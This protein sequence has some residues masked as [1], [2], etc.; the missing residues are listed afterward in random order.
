MKKLSW[1]VILVSSLAMAEAAMAEDI[2]LFQGVNPEALG[3]TDILLVMDNAANFSSSTVDCPTE[4]AIPGSFITGT[5]AGIQQ[6]ALSTVIEALPNDRI[7]LGIMMFTANGLQQWVDADASGNPIYGPC[8]QRSGGGGS[9]TFVGGCVVFPMTLV[10]DDD[11]T[12]ANTKEWLLNWIASWRTSGNTGNNVKAADAAVGSVMQEAWAYLKGS[13][14]GLSGA[15]YADSALYNV[16]EGECQGNAY[17]IYVGN[18]WDT[19]GNPND[20]PGY[21]GDALNSEDTLSGN[22]NNAVSAAMRTN[23]R[24]QRA[25]ITG[26]VQTSC[27]GNSGGQV[28]GN[29]PPA[30]ASFSLAFANGEESAALSWSNVTGETEWRLERQKASSATGN[31]SGPTEAFQILPDRVECVDTPPQVLSGGKNPSPQYQWYEYRLYAVNSAGN[32]APARTERIR[33]KNLSGV[34][35]TTCSDTIP[36]NRLVPQTYEFE[37]NAHNTNQELYGDEWARYLEQELNVRTYTIGLIQPDRCVPK[38]PALMSSMATAGKGKYYETNNFNELLGSLTEVFSLILAT[39]S[40]F[41]SVSLPISVNTQDTYLNQVYIGMFRPD[42]GARPRWLGNLKQYKLGFD[43]Q[44][45]LRLEDADG[46]Q[47]LADSSTGF[48]NACARSYWTPGTDEN[49]ESYWPEGE[50]YENCLQTG[51]SGTWDTPDGQIVEKGGAGYQLRTQPV[52]NRNLWT[53]GNAACSS[54]QAFNDTNS[55]ISTARLAAADTTERQELIDWAR[56]MN[57]AVDIG[58]IPAGS[59]RPSAHGDVV[60]SRPKA[61]NFQSPSESDPE[62]VIFYG[63]N[64]GTLRAINGNRPDGVDVAGAAPGE[65]LWA[66]LPPEF[67][68]EIKRLR[69]NNV[70]V[71]FKDFDPCSNTEGTTLCEPKPYGFDGP[72]STWVNGRPGDTDFEALIYATMR[73]GGRMVYAFDVKNIAAGTNPTLA[74]RFGCDDAGISGETVTCEDNYSGAGPD[75]A[76]E[77]GQTWSAPQPA[78]LRRNSGDIPLVIFGGGYDPCEDEDTAATACGAGG[79][80]FRGNNIY[81]LNAITGTLLAWFPTDRS[82]V[83][84]PIV[85]PD[86]NGYVEY[87][88]VSDLGGNIYRLSAPAGASIDTSLPSN[89]ISTRIARLGCTGS[90]GCN[91]K[92][93]YPPD[94]IRTLTGELVLLI[95]SGDREK[96]LPSAKYPYAT[97]VQNYFFAL[98]DIPDSQT[99]LNRMDVD[100][101]CAGDYICMDALALVGMADTTAAPSADPLTGVEYGG[102]ALELRNTEQTVTSAITVFGTVIFSTHTPESQTDAC[103][104]NLGVARAYQLNYRTG[105]GA[106]E[107]NNRSVEIEGGGLPPSPVAGLV[108]I[109]GEVYPFIIGGSARSALEAA[110]PGEGAFPAQPKGRRYWYIQR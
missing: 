102:W 83:A 72:V 9:S 46:D 63:A 88:Y 97:A 28:T 85:V 65:E 56:G 79:G 55:F 107:N 11:G 36:E 104:P 17:V 78:L 40:V 60:H 53:C 10:T 50:A 52:S 30:P 23:P 48:L 39:N 29:P 41:A 76:N 58:T 37:D 25:R 71:D 49:P 42:G 69:D 73:R 90:G 2:D 24:D 98:K 109:D 16:A 34:T 4:F 18:A 92:F 20:P 6:C 75:L 74:W 22:S 7:R 45:N 57:N 82:V 66:F 103:T 93:F 61:L 32:S 12:G 62:V 43:G 5:V 15:V 81:V 14:D 35:S 19:N 27:L 47:A 96:P 80:N 51:I 54:L 1:I 3:I 33:L 21:A 77:M 31:T 38:Y 8:P 67:Y 68:P 99:W 106:G 86:A 101:G 59:M 87:V 91:R 108:E 110:L 26:A 95:G 105:E 70:L 13:R 94:V 84:D 89:W 44:N 64:D 100:F